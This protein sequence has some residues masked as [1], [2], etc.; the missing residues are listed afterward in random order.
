MKN[1]KFIGIGVLLILVQGLKAQAPSWTLNPADYQYTMSIVGTG[2]FDCQST[3]DPNDRVAAF[4]NDSLAGYANFN[5]VVGSKSF[6]YLTIYS[7]VPS[8]EIIVYKMYDAS[9]NQVVEAKFGDVFQQNASVGT[10][11]NPFKFKTDYSLDALSLS[12]DTLFDYTTAGDTICTFALFNE[13]MLEEIAT[14]TFINDSAGLDNISFSTLN[15]FLIIEEDV[16]YITQNTYNIHVRATSFSGCT[17]D[18]SFVLIVFNTNVPPTDIIE[19]PASIEENDSIGTFVGLLQA[20]DATPI[21][22]HI[23]EFVGSSTDWP[24]NSAFTI[25]YDELLST[26]VFDYEI[27]KEYTLQIKVTDVTGN[28]YIDTFTVLINDLIE[29]GQELKAP[30]YMSPNGDGVNDFF[31]IENVELYYNYGL[32]FYNDNGNLVFDFTDKGYD[33]SWNGVSN[34]G[35]ELPSATYYYYFINKLNNQEFFKGK[36]FI[37]RANKY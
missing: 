2:L 23:F 17:F 35:N 16:D 32:Y 4:I 34:N 14:Y 5:T 7:N 22:Y 27:Q 19:N 20:V 11:V 28:F 18:E 13:L 24:D 26:E 31:A 12:T 3:V 25:N 30:N 1:L 9:T 21:D 8:G 29:Q 36:V 10:A 37:E 33:N 6:A 15:E